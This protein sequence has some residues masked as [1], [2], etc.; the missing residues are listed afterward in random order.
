MSRGIKHTKETY[1]VGLFA[2]HPENKVK[3][4]YDD[5]VFVNVDTHM[6][7]FCN[8]CGETF[9]QTPHSH[10]TGKGCPKCGLEKVVQGAR[11]GAKI[12][13]EKAKIISDAQ[14]GFYING[15]IWNSYK[16]GAKKRNLAFDITPEDILELYKKQNGLCAFTGA[17]LICNST[18][19][20]KNNWS[21][22]RIENNKGYTKDN[23]I[24]VAK[25]ANMFRNRST[26]KEFLEFCNMVACN[27][28]ATE[29]YFVMSPE[30]RAE[31]LENHSIRFTKKKD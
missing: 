31:R 16:K 7:I 22:D 25:T 12:S 27:K 6:D 19:S 24:L 4:N 28:N 8:G 15:A 3:Y 17:K 30:E 14:T 18:N 26:I 29:K 20:A 13:N 21:I 1:L 23:I 10:Y 5:S 2:R 11:H 9:S